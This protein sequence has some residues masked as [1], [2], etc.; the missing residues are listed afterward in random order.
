M[1]FKDIEKFWAKGT[2]SPGPVVPCYVYRGSRVFSGQPG[3]VRA[4]GCL[5]GRNKMSFR[6][7]RKSERVCKR[8]TFPWCHILRR[9]S[10]ESPI[11]G[12]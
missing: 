12:R 8:E 1:C 7:E 5:M 10:S 11:K 6:R 3:L 9:V 2:M 4:R